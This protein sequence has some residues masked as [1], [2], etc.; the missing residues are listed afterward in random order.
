MSNPRIIK[1]IFIIPF[2]FLVWEQFSWKIISILWASKNVFM[3][4]IISKGA[5]FSNYILIYQ[6]IMP[7][8]GIAR[9]LILFIRFSAQINI[10][11]L[12]LVF[13]NRYHFQKWVNGIHLL[14]YIMFGNVHNAMHVQLIACSDKTT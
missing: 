12:N 9:Y 7:V 6:N 2:I 14:P 5:C 8:L 11:F 3:K 1:T 4:H 10:V 13:C